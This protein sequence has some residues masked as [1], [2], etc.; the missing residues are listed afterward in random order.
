MFP[1][2]TA[3]RANLTSPPRPRF[4]TRAETDGCHLHLPLLLS[5]GRTRTGGAGDRLKRSQTVNLRVTACCWS[6]P[7]YKTSACPDPCRVNRAPAASSAFDRVAARPTRWNVTFITRFDGEASI[8]FSDG[9]HF[10]CRGAPQGEVCG[11]GTLSSAWA[12]LLPRGC[13]GNHRAIVE[14]WVSKGKCQAPLV[15]GVYTRGSY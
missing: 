2:D 4:C 13:P 15:W 11:G 5:S 14:G 7:R 12:H 10:H 1:V 9:D 6:S 8:I 3:C